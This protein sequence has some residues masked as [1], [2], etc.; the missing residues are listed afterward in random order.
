MI[1]T[2]KIVGKILG[3]KNSKDKWTRKYDCPSCG[4][5]EAK[6][7]TYKVGNKEKSLLLC[8]EC[9]YDEDTDIK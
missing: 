7:Q 5:H 8:T 1:F 2:H 6:K 3:D 9:G 4:A